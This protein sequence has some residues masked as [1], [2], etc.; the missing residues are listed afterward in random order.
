GDALAGDVWLIQPVSPRIVHREVAHKVGLE[1]LG[2]LP[3]R[4]IDSAGRAVMVCIDRVPKP[5]DA[6]V[7]IIEDTKWIAGWAHTRWER[8]RTPVGE[9]GFDLDYSLPE[10]AR[11]SSE[12]PSFPPARWSWEGS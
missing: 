10:S 1:L 5:F 6:R 9:P 7:D 11:H 3:P 12:L 2:Y 4:W 8:G